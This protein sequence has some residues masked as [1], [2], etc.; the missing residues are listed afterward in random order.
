MSAKMQ[1]ICFW[2]WEESLKVRIA[3]EV[4]CGYKLLNSRIL[5]ADF[6]SVPESAVQTAEEGTSYPAIL[7]LSREDRSSNER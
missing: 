3:R 7:V 6:G 1:H 2:M 4:N 5:A